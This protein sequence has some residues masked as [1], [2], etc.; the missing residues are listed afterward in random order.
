[1]VATKAW[2][3]LEF[4][5]HDTDLAQNFIIMWKAG[6]WWALAL[7]LCT[8]FRLGNGPLKNDLFLF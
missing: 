1:M 2:V 8:L 3:G 7:R 6:R 5:N 4:E